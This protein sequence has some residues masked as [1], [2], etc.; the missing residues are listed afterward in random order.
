MPVCGRAASFA[1]GGQLLAPGFTCW[2]SRGQYQACGRPVPRPRA[3]ISAMRPGAF[4]PLS[5]ATRFTASPPASGVLEAHLP[6]TLVR[7]ATLGLRFTTNYF[8]DGHAIM[9]RAGQN[10]RCRGLAGAAICLLQGTTTRRSRPSISAAR[11]CSPPADPGDNDQVTQALNTGRCDAFGSD[12]TLMASARAAL[13]RPDDWVILNERFSKE[14]YS[15]VVR[16]GDDN[17]FE[18]VR[19]YTMALIQAEEAASP[20]PPPRTPVA[21]APTPTRAASSAPC[22]RSAGPAPGPGLGVQRDPRGRQLRRDLR[23]AFRPEH[24]LATPAP[25]TTVDARRPALRAALPLS[26]GA[27]S[28]G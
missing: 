6:H 26:G 14:P 10:I 15:L 1:C 7:D 8:Y 13:T 27:P 19:W 12:A 5:F 17:W 21:P 18:I 20:R 16:R 9:V 23:P 24:P 25:R 11:T 22:P 2:N 4:V 28:G 3:A